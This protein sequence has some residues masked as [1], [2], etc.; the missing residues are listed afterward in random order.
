MPSVTGTISGSFNSFEGRW[1][2]DGHLA[3]FHGN[4]NPSVERWDSNATL[5]YDEIDDLAGASVVGPAG[6]PSYVG[7]DSTSLTLIGQ[8]GKQVKITGNLTIPISQRI[9]ISG[10][11]VWTVR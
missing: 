9:T 11:G 2:V 5:E 8:G 10:Q 1:I 4:I 6:L 7:A 3:E